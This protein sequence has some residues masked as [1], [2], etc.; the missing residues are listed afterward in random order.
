MTSAL[1]LTGGTIDRA[2]QY[3]NDA[4][5]IAARLADGTSGVL[6]VWQDLNLVTEEDGVKPAIVRGAAAAQLLASAEDT[7]FLGLDEAGHALFAAALPPASGELLCREWVAAT[8]FRD[9]A[10]LAP[11]LDAAGGALLAYARALLR[12]HR[13]HRF[14]GCCGAATMSSNGGHLRLCP[15]A[16]CG[17]RQFPRTDPVVIMLVTRGDVCLLARQPS[18]IAGLYSTLAGFVEPGESLEDAVVREVRE[19]AGLLATAVT[20]IAS[21]PW[22]FPQSLMLGFRAEVCGGERLVFDT[23][24]LEDA[25]W[26]GR[27]DFA[28]LRQRGIRLPY[29][30]TIARAMIDT[31]LAE[32]AT[33]ALRRPEPAAGR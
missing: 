22:P 31:W 21:Q 1:V 33:G 9:L 30:G 12:W 3:R 11:M 10:K 17:E 13:C 5:W 27:D 26:F 16:A 2:A 6:P 23:A 25:R 20:Y 29:R 14:C 24:E 28:T 8:V 4:A 19:E 32:G 18:W 7:A 15:N